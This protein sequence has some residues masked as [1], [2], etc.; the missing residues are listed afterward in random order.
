MKTFNQSWLASYFIAGTQDV[1]DNQL[2]PTLERALKSGI[3]CFQFREKNPL[4]PLTRIQKKT[5]AI[6][7]QRL[8]TKY[9]VPFFIDDDLPLALEIQADGIHVGQNDQKIQN[10]IDQSAGQLLIGFSCQTPEKIKQANQLSGIAYIG[11]G[12]VFPTKSKSDAT[13]PLGIAGLNQLLSISQLP[14][15]AIGGISENNLAELATTTVS[16]VAVISL[17]AK[18]PNIEQTVQSINHYFKLEDN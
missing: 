13:A 17:I 11:S 5:L 6:E 8:C 1:A 14:I 7:C 18:S 15:V 9:Q 16:G 2:L 10:V 12:P 3:S 4:N